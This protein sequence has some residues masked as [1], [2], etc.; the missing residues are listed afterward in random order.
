MCPARNRERRERATAAIGSSRPLRNYYYHYYYCCYYYYYLA[1]RR[2]GRRSCPRLG[3]SASRRAV[4]HAAVGMGGGCVCRRAAVHLVGSSK[5]DASWRKDSSWRW[6][7]LGARWHGGTGPT[8]AGVAFSAPAEL[9]TTLHA[10]RYTQSTVGRRR[11]QRA[12]KPRCTRHLD[13]PRSDVCRVPASPSLSRGGHTARGRT[14]PA[15]AASLHCEPTARRPARTRSPP[16]TAAAAQNAGATDRRPPAKRPRAHQRKKQ[17]QTRPFCP[18][19]SFPAHA[20]ACVRPRP[21][22]AGGAAWRTRLRPAQP[23]QRAT[24]RPGGQRTSAVSGC[25]PAACVPV[26]LPSVAGWRARRDP[27]L[28]ASWCSADRHIL[29]AIRS[30]P[31][32]SP[33]NLP[34]YRTRR[35]GT[36]QRSS[37]A[38]AERTLTGGVPTPSNR[39]AHAPPDRLLAAGCPPVRARLLPL[40]PQSAISISALRLAP[41]SRRSPPAV[42]L[43]PSSPPTVLP[44]PHSC[45]SRCQPRRSLTRRAAA[46]ALVLLRARLGQRHPKLRGSAAERIPRRRVDTPRTRSAHDPGPKRPSAYRSPPPSFLRLAVSRVR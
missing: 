23:G 30:S 4:S 2:G 18:Q 21:P 14:T 6:V 41:S 36:Q 44:L 43:Q 20:P 26:R 40:L 11:R 7:A 16:A 46:A 35:P 5:M 45:V 42:P 25:L 27:G 17:K 12:H 1:A 38:C 32:T 22:L 29:S 8:D 28:A 10:S 9:H 33:T 3:G 34:S 39:G 15:T 13:R 19:L 37:P 24:R 31:P